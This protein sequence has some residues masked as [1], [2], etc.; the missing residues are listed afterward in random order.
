[1]LRYWQAEG[2]C[3]EEC[4]AASR[5]I[6]AYE[7][8]IVTL[9]PETANWAPEYWVDIA[10]ICDALQYEYGNNYRFTPR[11]YDVIISIF[12]METSTYTLTSD[13]EHDYLRCVFNLE[14]FSMP[15]AQAIWPN[16]TEK[17]IIKMYYLAK[18]FVDNDC[19]FEDILSPCY[20]YEVDEDVFTHSWIY[21]VVQKWMETGDLHTRYENDYKKAMFEISLSI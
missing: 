18:D 8:F 10:H 14:H 4:D 3:Q 12:R 13:R 2:I 20:V 11:D 16:N 9:C 17:N 6:T 1:M 21:T 5:Y 19:A 7:E 15:W